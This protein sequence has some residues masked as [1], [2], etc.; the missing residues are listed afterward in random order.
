MSGM[1]ARM[2]RGCCKETAPVEFQQYTAKR[3]DR[4]FADTTGKE[5]YKR[6]DKTSIYFTCSLKEIW[7][8]QSM[9]ISA[10]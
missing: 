10:T 4:R 9:H 8:F 5:S 7:Q 3:F 6:F 2:L 1:S